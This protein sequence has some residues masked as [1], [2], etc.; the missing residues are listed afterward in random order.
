MA[1][2]PII[3]YPKTVTELAELFESEEMCI[4]Y[5]TRVRWPDGLRCEKCKGTSFWTSGATSGLVYT[6]AACRHKT[7]LLAGTIF[8]DTKL[9]LRKWFR[10]MWEIVRKKLGTSALS[11]KDE[12][13]VSYK[14]A[15]LMLH[16]LR[17]AM[18]T[19]GRFK[20][21]GV[22]EVDETFYGS[23]EEG[24]PGRGA[25]DKALIAVAVEVV[26]KKLGRC[27]M[28][29][30][31]SASAEDLMPFTTDN[32]MEGSHVITDGWSGY[33]QLA[34]L[35]YGHS[36][37]SVSKDKEVLNHVHLVV[38]LLKRW[39]LGTLQGGVS[40][41]QLGYY[42]DEFVFR[43]NRRTSKNRRFFFTG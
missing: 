41:E 42:L 19:P 13:G 2:S 14:T 20:L 4:N 28:A 10:A 3:D 32:V 1:E 9:P 11:F 12:L 30:I 24:R 43:F 40:K 35:G 16:K 29:I 39:L 22:V 21:K 17:R 27:R 25:Q 7:S 38:S 26:G 5:L 8:Q 37:Q 18:V 23:H 31:D 15:W 6:C 33:S 36:V 34:K